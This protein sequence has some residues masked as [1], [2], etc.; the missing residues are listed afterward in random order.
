MSALTTQQKK[1]VTDIATAVAEEMLNPLVLGGLSPSITFQ[2][3]DGWEWK[4]V[5]EANGFII[6]PVGEKANSHLP[7][8]IILGDK[9]GNPLQ[10]ID[11]D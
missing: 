11:V 5:A 6:H 7:R 9:D 8:R 4:I 3:I 2:T 1:E 10:W